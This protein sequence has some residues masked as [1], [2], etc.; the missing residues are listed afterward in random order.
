MKMKSNC[1][2]F[3]VLIVLS[4]LSMGAAKPRLPEFA[5]KPFRFQEAK[6]IGREA[7][8]TRRDV[9]DV[10]RVGDLYYIWY[11][12]SKNEGRSWEEKGSSLAVI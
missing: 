7:G 8:V 10:I 11:A 6:G 2:V 3:C 12:V 9:S 4:V 5:G 1:V